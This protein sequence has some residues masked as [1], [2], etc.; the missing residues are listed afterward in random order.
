MTCCS[1]TPYVFDDC[2]DLLVSQHRTET[3][4]TATALTLVT[5]D[6]AELRTVLQ[7][8]D[9]VGFVIEVAVRCAT[10]EVPTIGALAGLTRISV[11]PTLRVSTSAAVS[12]TTEFQVEDGLADA[13]CFARG[14]RAID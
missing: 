11:A 6:L 3:R 12:A 10:G 1:Q 13:G 7:E 9:H 4:H 14:N 8:R 5:V 2:F